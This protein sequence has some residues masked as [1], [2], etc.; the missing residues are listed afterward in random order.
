MHT[1]RTLRGLS[2]MLSAMLLLSLA[3]VASMAVLELGNMRAET[4]IRIFEDT[5]MPITLV[6]VDVLAVGGKYVIVV[7]NPSQHTVTVDAVMADTIL[8]A[9]DTQLQPGEPLILV[10]DKRPSKIAVVVVGGEIYTP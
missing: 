3:T 5:A 6:D 1:G 4:A 10:L 8:L 7:S 9:S 2:E